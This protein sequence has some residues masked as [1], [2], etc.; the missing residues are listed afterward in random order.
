LDPVEERIVAEVRN[1]TMVSPER[2]VA[3]MDAVRYIEARGIE[4]A[5]VECGV[6][7]GGS[8]L[9]MIKMLQE[10][11]VDNR[12]I[13]LYDTFE[14][15]TE[16]GEADTSPFEPPAR[17]T[18]LATPEGEKPWN[19]AFDSAIY[20][21]DFVRQ[22]IASSGYPMD[23]VH[24]VKGPVEE[25]LP[26]TMPQSVALARLDTDWYESTLHE[27]KHLYPAMPAGGVLIIDDFG[28]WDGAR[29]AVE[30]YFSSAAGPILLTR[31]DYTGRMGIKQ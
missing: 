2:L 22:V 15:M 10:L 30:E 7:R 28:H 13:Y 1:Y 19:W 14:G 27:L 11:E 21:I 16:P 6:W 25:T 20:D 3:I 18:W 24:F 17:D 5:L 12:E 29:R 4:G 9:T 8:V 23:R 31:T 26:G